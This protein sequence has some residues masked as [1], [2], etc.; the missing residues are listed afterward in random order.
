MRLVV[1]VLGKQGDLPV[2]MPLDHGVVLLA[3]VPLDAL[4]GRTVGNSTAAVETRGGSGGKLQCCNKK[5]GSVISNAAAEVTEESL[6]IKTLTGV[7]D[8][9][10]GTEEAE[11]LVKIV[12]SS[13]PRIILG[14]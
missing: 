5:S 4:F 13:V 7:L 3:T 1:L 14:D 2:F 9:D 10:R 6:L 8:A 11:I 12:G